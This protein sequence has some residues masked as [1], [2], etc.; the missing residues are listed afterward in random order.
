MLT[1]MLTLDFI[2][3]ARERIA[4]HVHHT[5][6]MSSRAF[7]AIAGRE[8]WFKCENFQRGGAFKMRGAANRIFALDAQERARGVAAFSSGNHAQAVAL[9]A[10]DAGTRAVIVMPQDAPRAKVE[11]TRGYGAEIVFYDRQ[12]DDREAVA[13]DVAERGGGLVLVPPYDDYHVMAGQGT[14]VLE[15]LEE[16]QDL[17]AIVTP[18]GGGGLFAGASTVAKGVSAG[19]IRCFGVEPETGDDTRQSLHAGER[20]TIPPP[21]TIADGARVQSPGALTFPFVQ[22]NA[23]DVLVV[24]DTELIEALKFL[25]FRLK[26]LVEPTGALAVAVALFNKLPADV[27]RVGVVISGGN[28]DA[29]ALARIVKE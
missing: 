4:P 25:L 11:A 22:K 2:R 17:D 19:R 8:V 23:E 9:A 21:P 29:D 27:R 18:I 16:V 5:P 6:V 1:N 26:I 28:V 20:M 12:R 14:C 7:N 24:S 15:L 10:R 3:E 13:R